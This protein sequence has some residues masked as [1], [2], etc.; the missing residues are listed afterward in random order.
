M[1]TYNPKI[2]KVEA[3]GL[4]FQDQPG[5]YNRIPSKKKNKLNIKSYTKVEKIN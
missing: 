1:Y 2:G 3:G 4:E 5:L